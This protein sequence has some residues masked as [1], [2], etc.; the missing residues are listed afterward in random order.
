MNPRHTTH[1][2]RAAADA[3]QRPKMYR[4]E[5]A[6]RYL[7]CGGYCNGCPHDASRGCLHESWLRR[8]A[9]EE[10]EKSPAQ[11]IG[12]Y[13]GT[14]YTYRPERLNDPRLTAAMVEVIR[15]HAQ[16]QVDADRKDFNI[17]GPCPVH[18]VRV[19]IEAAM[20]EYP[21]LFREEGKP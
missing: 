10:E 21:E 20:I 4:H 5:D 15:I 3:L 11:H 2:E 8:P 12:E 14:K 13:T 6:F 19:I 18:H 16:Y 7:G 9:E 1:Q 17:E